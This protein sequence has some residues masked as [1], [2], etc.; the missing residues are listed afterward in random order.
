MKINP[1]K[2]NESHLKLKEDDDILDSLDFNIHLVIYISK[3]DNKYDRKI[4][5]SMGY[6][7]KKLIYLNVWFTIR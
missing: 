7:R 4:K 1:N 2:F 5:N 3:L 6:V